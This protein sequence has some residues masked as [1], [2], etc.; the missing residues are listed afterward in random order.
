MW[1]VWIVKDRNFTEKPIREPFQVVYLSLKVSDE[2]LFI[3]I[4]PT[5]LYRFL[6][7][8]HS[9]LFAQLFRLAF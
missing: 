6:T 8:T 1:Q 2:N 3:A 9:H 5:G 4:H 7:K